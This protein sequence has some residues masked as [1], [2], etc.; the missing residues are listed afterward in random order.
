[1][2]PQAGFEPATNRLTAD[3][4]TT[5][6]LRSVNGGGPQATQDS[7]APPSGATQ[8]MGTF[9]CPVRLGPGRL[10]AVTDRE[11]NGGCRGASF[12][13]QEGVAC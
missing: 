8:G 13:T 2:A 5:E 10:L 11:F 3:R 1:M 7:V 9:L 4:S 12:G 6:L